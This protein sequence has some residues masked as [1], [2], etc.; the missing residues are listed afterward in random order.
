MGVALWPS[1]IFLRK[2]KMKK[3]KIENDKYELCINHNYQDMLAF[4]ISQGSI[5][6][7]SINVILLQDTDPEKWLLELAE[8]EIVRDSQGRRIRIGKEQL[9]FNIDGE[10]GP[11]L[12]LTYYGFTADQLRTAIKETL[13]PAP[14]PKVDWPEWVKDGTKLEYDSSVLEWFL[15]PY[16]LRGINQ[17]CQPPIQTDHLDKT[18][19]YVKGQE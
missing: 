17:V 7:M 2:N 13:A 6:L 10:F 16:W 14:E 5:S 19:V 12:P 8:G 9:Y 4:R 3:I 18:K 11:T 1:P 15:A